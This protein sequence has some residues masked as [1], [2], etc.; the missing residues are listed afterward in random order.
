M[1]KDFTTLIRH[2]FEAD[3]IA[4]KEVKPNSFEFEYIWD[5]LN[6]YKVY[7]SQKKYYQGFSYGQS[8]KKD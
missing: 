1:E 6:A 3:L 7:E 4:I 5:C 2:N 8:N